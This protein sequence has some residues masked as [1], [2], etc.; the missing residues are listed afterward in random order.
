MSNNTTR[1]LKLLSIIGWIM[2]AVS[3]ALGYISINEKL[4]K[5]YDDQIIIIEL[6]ADQSI[7]HS[8]KEK[9]K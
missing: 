6:I 3:V 9:N 5:I 8:T 7:F 1:I 4:D 2:I